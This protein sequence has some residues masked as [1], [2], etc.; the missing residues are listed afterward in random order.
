[1]FRLLVWLLVSLPGYPVKHAHVFFP[2]VGLLL[3]HRPIPKHCLTFR[4]GCFYAWIK[5]I[6]LLLKA[7]HHMLII[8]WQV[9][10]LIPAWKPPCTAVP[11]YPVQLD[12]S[13]FRNVHMAYG[14]CPRSGRYRMYAYNCKQQDV[15]KYLGSEINLHDGSED[16]LQTRVPRQ[17]FFISIWSD[18][19]A[20]TRLPG[21]YADSS[22]V[23]RAEPN[24]DKPWRVSFFSFCQCQSSFCLRGETL[25]HRSH[26][27]S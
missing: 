7:N 6:K 25:S 18:R 8:S 2:S 4:E 13:A 3:G 12:P 24:R 5:G 26:V 22:D 10:S 19:Y 9:V 23:S 15:R 16:H 1:M 20:H 11:G 14:S 21:T 17:I 27:M